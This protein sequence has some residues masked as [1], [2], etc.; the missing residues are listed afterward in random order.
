MDVAKAKAVLEADAQAQAREKLAECRRRL[1]EA[2]LAAAQAE[3]GSWACAMAWNKVR[4]MAGLCVTAATEEY[5]RRRAAA[6]RG[7]LGGVE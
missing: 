4:A 3:I 6:L 2:A 7:P 5:E 1:R